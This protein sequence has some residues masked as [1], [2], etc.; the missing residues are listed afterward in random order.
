MN[1]TPELGGT[2]VLVDGEP[3]LPLSDSLHA[4]GISRRTAYR[5]RDK[6]TLTFRKKDG[7][8]YCRTVQ[9]VRL[10]TQ[11]EAANASH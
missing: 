6:G 11:R 5:W 1:D 4:L 10:K 8:I 7:L 3:Y 2:H 9:V